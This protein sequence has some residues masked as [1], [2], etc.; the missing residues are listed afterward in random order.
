[1]P[2]TRKAAMKGGY[3][4]KKVDESMFIEQWCQ[5]ANDACAEYLMFVIL[6][7]CHLVLTVKL[8]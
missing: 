8:A 5:L 4:N 2:I 6:V 3:L 7:S 1:M